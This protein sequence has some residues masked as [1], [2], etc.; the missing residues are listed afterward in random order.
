MD[1]SVLEN[2]VRIGTVTAVNTAKCMAR[3]KYQDT[4]ITSG[5][6]FVLQHSGAALSIKPDGKHKHSVPSVGDTSTED[7]HEHKRSTVARWMPKVNDNVLC[8]YLPAFNADGFIL[9]GIA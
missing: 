3:V 6:L 2:I 5:W 1:E 7:N 9:G 4:G 8:L